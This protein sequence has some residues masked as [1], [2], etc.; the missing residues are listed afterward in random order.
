MSFSSITFLY[1]FLPVMLLAY[2][3]TPVKFRNITLLTGSLIFYFSGEPKYLLL[4]LFTTIIAYSH[5]LIIHKNLG[6]RIAKLTLISFIAISLSTLFFY[7][8]FDFIILNINKLIGTDF[9]PLGLSLPIG[10][11]FFTFQTMSYMIDVYREKVV[12][13]KNILKLATYVTLFPQLIAGPIVK[14]KTIANELSNRTHSYINFSYGIHRFI[15]GLGKKVLIA[16]TLGELAQI[17][18][19]TTH[20][21]IVFYWLGAFAFAL[22]IYYDFSGYSDMAIGLGRIFG[23][24]FLENFNYPYMSLSISEFWN[25]WHISLGSWFKDYVYIPLG[26]N[27]TR[28]MKW[29]RNIFIVWFLT[30]F[31]H[32][33]S[34]NFIFWGL[35]LGTFIIFEKLILLKYLQKLSSG[36]RHLYVI[37]VIVMSFV[38]FNNDTM[39]SL[40]E[41]FSGMFGLLDISFFTF[42][43]IYYAKSY[44]LTLL[45]AIIGSTPFISNIAKKLFKSNKKIILSI[46]TPL[47]YIILL[48]IITGYLIDSSFNPFLYFRF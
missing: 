28:S 6:N 13:Q 19:T 3:I 47:F 21:S 46:I 32:G 9:S 5:S 22:Q 14:Y 4:L 11:S 1:Y 43:T 10:I 39:S 48:L 42:E 45:F 33:A 26:G 29:I 25:R 38:I 7:K 27:R 2:F 20:P 35:Y 31:W 37:F 15:I 34:W 41:Y 16:N 40:I 36:V 17:A 24:H 30:G 18:Q 12:P 8:Y 23:F 44:A